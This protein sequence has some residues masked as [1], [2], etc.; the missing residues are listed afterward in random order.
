MIHQ[1]H[2]YNLFVEILKLLEQRNIPDWLFDSVEH[3]VQLSRYRHIDNVKVLASLKDGWD[4]IFFT[5][6]RHET[7]SFIGAIVELAWIL[8]YTDEEL[9]FMRPCYTKHEQVKLGL[10]FFISGKSYQLKTVE[11]GPK[12][13]HLE[14][15]YKY[16]NTKADYL[17]LIDPIN[18]K[19]YTLPLCEWKKL[20]A[21]DPTRDFTR[22]MFWVNQSDVVSAGGEVRDL[23]EFIKRAKP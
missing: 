6:D 17:V 16:L 2:F 19:S 12:N 3:G 15:R 14:I 9:M 5:N 4:G 1:L 7:T 23:P 20:R 21:T 18:A 13:G 22:Q 11:L 10:D 8:S